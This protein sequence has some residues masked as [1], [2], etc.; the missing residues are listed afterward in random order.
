[1]TGLGTKSNRKKPNVKST[2]GGPKVKPL[3]DCQLFGPPCTFVTYIIS[4]IS[5]QEARVVATWQTQAGYRCF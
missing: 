4:E 5:N 2:D 1:M 3:F